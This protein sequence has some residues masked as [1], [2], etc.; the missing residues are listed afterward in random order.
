[1]LV[2]FGALLLL[3]PDFGQTMLVAIVWGTLFFMAGMPWIWIAMLAFFGVA[4]IGL[5]YAV[6]PHVTAR[7]DRFFDPGSG[8]TY[9]VDTA[10][11]AF[12]RGGWF[13]RG[14]GEGTVKNVLPDSHTDFVFAVAAEEFGILACLFLVGLFAFMVLRVLLK[15][16]HETDIFTRFAT[17]GLIIMFGLQALINMAVNLQLLPAKGMTLPFISAGGSSL[18]SMSLAM[19]MVLGMTSRRTDRETLRKFENQPLVGAVR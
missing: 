17:S 11:A 1:M 6:L 13:G 5:A 7:I 8:D 3:Q 9:Q 2:I 19:G 16:Y 4:G 18:L 14:P 10:L 12:I 15:S